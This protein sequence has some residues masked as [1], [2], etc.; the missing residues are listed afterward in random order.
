MDVESSIRGTCDRLD[1]L[2]HYSGWFALW[3]HGHMVQGLLLPPA[4][5]DKGLANP[6][7]RGS[8]T[9][10]RQSGRNPLSSVSRTV[11]QVCVS[12]T[13]S[14]VYGQP[15]DRLA[16]QPR[17]GLLQR[18]LKIGRRVQRSAALPIHS[19]KTTKPF[20][21]RNIETNSNGCGAGNWGSHSSKCPTPKTNVSKRTSKSNCNDMGFHGPN[22]RN[23][24][25]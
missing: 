22:N 14:R 15:S 24:V 18:T 13:T 25:N 1:H 20:T 3:I 23:R 12:Q 21:T 7:R 5:G 19:T 17:I 2:Y 4:L 6:R 8:S 10:K 16:I 9:P 11:L